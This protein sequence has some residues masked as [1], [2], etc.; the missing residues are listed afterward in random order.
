MVLVSSEHVVSV[1]QLYL[2]SSIS[3]IFVSVDPLFLF[4]VDSPFSAETC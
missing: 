3:V 2:L 4:T 1:C